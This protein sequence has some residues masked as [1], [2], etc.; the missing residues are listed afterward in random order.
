MFRPVLASFAGALVL[1]APVLA[2]EKPRPLMRDF[3]GL[4]VHTVQFKPQLYA[5]V[6]RVV[7]DYHPI[8]WDFGKDT[9]YEPKFPRARNG[10]DW[11]HL[12]GGW[13]RDGYKI[14]ACLIFD[15]IAPDA[16]KD[17][18]KDAAQYG[19][20]FARAFGPGGVDPLVEAV[21]IG[22]EP[23]H[24]SD[25]QYRTIFEAMARA[26][27]E[28]DPKLRIAMCAANLGPSGKYSKSVDLV[29]GLESL[30]DIIN[31]HF[32]AQAE[33]W[34]TFRRSYPEDPKIDFL[35]SAQHVLKWRADNAPGKEIWV[36]E[37][38]WDSSTKPAP[39]SG[40]FEKWIGNS[41]TQQAQWIVRGYMLFAALGIDRA[42][43][44]FFNDDDQPQIH[45]SSGLTRA[46]EP[47]PSFHAVAWL[48][49]SLG[50]YR[51]ERVVSDVPEHPYVFRFVH[52]SE[53]AKSITAIWKPAGESARMELPIGKHA[54]RKAERMPLTAQP[55]EPL[56]LPTKDG[57]FEI[58][59]TESPV[60]IWMEAP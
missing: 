42:Y 48:L 51:F 18:S 27:R 9:D 55:A 6:T 53:P 49:R 44:Y 11:K 31:V 36:T 39:A 40:T 19:R 14:N 56:A 25:A 15:E 29:K 21:E 3:I 43:L 57:K 28:T 47:K 26:V 60:F 5:P 8:N 30:Y 20:A 1:A 46:F 59:A 58:E 22:N 32:Y 54:F 35:A 33:P 17:F 38:G 50:D 7:R 2:A 24:Y 41:D 10:V 12:Y 13:Q 52:G 16:W 4:N 37:F 23:S 45:G 34:P